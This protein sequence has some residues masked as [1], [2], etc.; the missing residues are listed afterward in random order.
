MIV[1]SPQSAVCHPAIS[2]Q[3]FVKGGRHLGAETY[4]EQASSAVNPP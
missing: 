1:F 2:L 3:A 4:S